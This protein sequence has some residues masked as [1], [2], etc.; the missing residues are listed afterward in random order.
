MSLLSMSIAKQVGMNRTTA[1]AVGT[2]LVTGTLP[3]TAVVSDSL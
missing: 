1:A 3:Q 2:A